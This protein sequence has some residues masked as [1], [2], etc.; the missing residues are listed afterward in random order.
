MSEKKILIYALQSSKEILNKKSEKYLVYMEQDK[1][2]FM[3][4]IEKKE[5]DYIR[6]SYKITNEQKDL[7]KKLTKKYDFERLVVVVKLEELSSEIYN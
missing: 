6:L 4:K 2:S 7:W 1:T 5:S 3:E